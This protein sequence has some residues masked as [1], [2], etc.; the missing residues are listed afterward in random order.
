LHEGPQGPSEEL[1]LT[2]GIWGNQLHDEILVFNQGWWSKSRS[3]WAEVQKADWKDVIL[4]AVC[5]IHYAASE[6]I[7]ITVI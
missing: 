7:L 2:A 4:D 5:V 3:L 6:V 1:L